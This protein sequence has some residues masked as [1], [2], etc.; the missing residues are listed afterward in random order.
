MGFYSLQETQVQ[1]LTWEDPP[2]KEMV[3]NTMCLPGK[4]H[5]QQNLTGCSPQVCKESDTIEHTHTHTH[6]HTHIWEIGL[7][8]LCSEPPPCDHVFDL[9]GVACSVLSRHISTD[10]LGT[11][12]EHLLSTV[13]LRRPPRVI[14]THCCRLEHSSGFKI[15][16]GH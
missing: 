7:T 10:H 14:K 12:L 1:S 6:T 9:P 16:S 15:I 8:C 13:G 4:S 11:Q 2:E 3:T 5:G